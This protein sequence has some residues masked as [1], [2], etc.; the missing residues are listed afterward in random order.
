[1]IGKPKYFL[2]LLFVLLAQ[3]SFS[4]EERTISGI[5]TDGIGMPLPGVNVII[6]GTTTGVQTDFDGNYSIE[7]SPGEVLVFSFIGLETT[8]YT[9]A[10]NDRID[11]VLQPD[12][13]QLEEVVVTALGISRE[14][15]SLG[16]ATQELNA[17][18]VQTPGSDNVVNSLSGKVAGVQII[19]NTNIG[20]STNV[21]IRGNTSLTGDNQA[22]FV[23]DGVPVS[24]A[25][26]NTSDQRGGTGGFDYGNLASDINPDNIKSINV[27]KGAAATALYGSRATNGAVI[28]T[29]KTGAGLNKPTIEINSSVTTGFIDKSTWPEFQYEYGG[30]Y[31][32]L[33]GPNGNDYFVREDIDG[34]GILDRVQPD[35]TYGSFGGRFDPNIM[36][37]QWDAFYQESPNYM[38][39]TPWT[40]PENK[41]IEFFETPL[42]FSNSI[43]LSGAN[44]GANYRIS[45]TNFSQGGILPNSEIERNNISVNTSFDL[46]D[47]LSA[48][49]SANYVKTDALGRNRTG[50]ESSS[51]GGGNVIASMRKY[52][53]M[54]ADILEL[55]DAYFNTG[56]NISP[57]ING[58]IDN[59]Y[60]VQYENYQN[61]T[62]DRIYGNGSLSYELADWLNIEGRVSLDTYTFIQEERQNTG[63]AGETGAYR[64]RNIN[65]SE[66]NY[67]LMLNFNRNITEIF[68][69]SGVLGTNI[70]RNSVNSISAQTNGGLVIPGLYSLS[71][72]VNMPAAPN[73][74]DQQIGVDGYY[75]LISL[76][77]N[78]MIYLD[79]TGR[80]DY[81]STLPVENS[82]FFYP[83]VATSFVFSELLDNNSFISFGKLRLNYAEVGSGAPANSLIDVLNKPTPFGAIPLY[84]V[85][86]TKNN[87][88]LL[89][90]ST[91]SYEAGL[92][93]RVFNGRLRTDF[94]AYNTVT[95]DQIIPVSISPTTGYGSKFVN[96]GEV[97]NVGLEIALSGTPI[98][99]EEFNWN[100]RV[101]W[102]RNQSEVK[103]LF[104]GGDNLQLSS[105]RNITI[106]AAVGEPFGAIRGSDYIYV[107]GQPVI[108]QTTG[109]FER[110]TTKNHII[111]NIS[112]DWNAGLINSFSYNNWSLSFLIDIQKGGDIFSEDIDTGYRSGLYTNTTGLNELGNPVR[113]PLS[114]GG[115]IILAGVTPNGEP[116]QVRTPMDNYRNAIGNVKAPDIHF[117]FDA[118]Y[119]KL[120]EMTLGY[121]FPIS[122][123]LEGIN[124]TALRANL[125]GSNLWIIHKNLP[126]AD[127][128]ANLS[129]GSAIQGFQNGVLPTTRNISF[130]LRLQF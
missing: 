44:Q 67:D 24:N 4:Q 126:Y 12:S 60:W 115:G 36:V 65:S 90:E 94:S 113:D 8:E 35:A 71:N 105:L 52:W 128:E 53:V 114:E 127:P 125:V 57:F 80:V 11:V 64:R 99:T 73:E 78:N 82:T 91:V 18:D 22:L 1:M 45:Y 72:S 30:G 74:V 110:T 66:I 58:T 7:A 17:E 10:N 13:S 88:N 34:D 76:G 62:R 23:V 107:N 106:N 26:H 25:S 96:A 32:P 118:S 33:Y 124:I 129:A 120:R 27:L 123:F 121:N 50:N 43:S 97:Q 47:R 89:P 56:R 29:T 95:R 61:D 81:S 85:N 83:S 38:Q 69:L 41:L 87:P 103:S 77:Y 109:E 116:N 2:M 28:I 6:Q 101:N 63:T 108:N 79:V 119:V 21:T 54:N 104:E 5:V 15:R 37:Y 9:V 102:A 86:S 19:N 70:R 20:G 100:V 16:Y 39:P 122:S 31:G 98:T 111:G 84:G 68:N 3:I 92:E 55:R 75:G 51:V 59:P 112:P 117:V 14:K 46:N 130:N 40:A 49:A 42:T 48:T 93:L